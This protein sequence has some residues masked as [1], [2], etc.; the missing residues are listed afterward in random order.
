VESVSIGMAEAI[1][2]PPTG[3]TEAAGSNHPLAPRMAVIAFVN[4][5]IT[6]A[7]IWGSFSVLLGA[8]ETRLGVGR[9]LST[10]AVPVVNLATAALAPVA[11][12]LAT[13]HSLRSIML[14]GAALSVAGFAVLALTASYPLYLVAFGLLLGPGMAAG[15]VLP[16]TLVTRWY[17]VNRGRTLGIVCAPIVI[18]LVPLASTWMLQSHGLAATYAFLATLSAVSLIANFFVI[19]R[20][21]ASDSAARAADTNGA[22]GPA[23]PGAMTMAML[24]RSP[25]FWALMLAYIASITGS[26]LITS[27]MVPLA[28]SWGMSATLAA[29]LIS[30]QSF[31]GIGGT[32]LFG[33]VADR[34]GGALALAILVFDAA[35]LWTLLLFQPA[36]PAAVVIVGLIGVHGAGAIP[37]LGVALSESF[38]RESFSRA[39]GLVN[40][41]NLPFAVVS[42]PAA[43]MVFAHT[44][45]YAGAIVGQVAFLALGSVLV[46]FARRGRRP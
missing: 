6:V 8:V 44:G 3:Q 33:W 19:D 24:L 30:I 15:V 31:A 14:L 46:L 18:A 23:A 20:P 10:L 4:Q 9:E 12:V 21:P 39:Y 2:T 37:V 36:F 34:L 35:L 7:C 5:N 27:Q 1:L 42:V 45:S 26:I 28:R 38:G 25:L 40:L 41:V 11:G 29:T 16:A 22:H 32:V 43:A 13:R 17:K